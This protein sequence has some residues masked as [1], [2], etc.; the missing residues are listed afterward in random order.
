MKLIVSLIYQKQMTME[1]TL[2][3]KMWIGLKGILKT[4]YGFLLVC[5]RGVYI[6]LHIKNDLWDLRSYKMRGVKEIGVKE[7]SQV[8]GN[9]QLQMAIQ[10]IY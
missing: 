9:E 2:N 10:N 4:S 6:E 5:N 1:L 3:T 7:I 8:Y